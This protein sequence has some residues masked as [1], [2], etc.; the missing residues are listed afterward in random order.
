MQ[1]VPARFEKAFACFHSARLS[2]RHNNTGTP[3]LPSTEMLAY[4]ERVRLPREHVD[5]QRELYIYA[6]ER[7]RNRAILFP[8]CSSRGSVGDLDPLTPPPE[9][10]AIIPLFPLPMIGLPMPLPPPPATP[11]RPWPPL[12]PGPKF[13]RCCSRICCCCCCGGGPVCCWP[14]NQGGEA[15]PWPEGGPGPNLPPP[16]PPPAHGPL[17]PPFPAIPCGLK[18]LG[19]GAPPLLL[20]LLL[21]IWIGGRCTCSEFWGG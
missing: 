18:P 16:P 12:E 15:F 6:A 2:R 10:S 14:S 20:L 1:Y 3:P 13:C 4:T 9:S 7:H 11:P 8:R 5:Q 21:C 17:F 19:P